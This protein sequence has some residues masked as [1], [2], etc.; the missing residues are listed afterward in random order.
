[1]AENTT[2][3]HG[4]AGLTPETATGS[5]RAKAQTSPKAVT[6]THASRFDD[7]KNLRSARNRSA[8][9]KKDTIGITCP[10]E[11]K[12]KTG[13]FWTASVSRSKSA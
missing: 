12:F 1:L 5:Q 3:Q 4:L 7:D 8:A 9:G 10:N 13:A 6:S 2:G 11:R